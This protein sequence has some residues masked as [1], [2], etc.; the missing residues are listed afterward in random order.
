MS[1]PAGKMNK[2][3]MRIQFVVTG[4]DAPS[5]PIVGVVLIC[6]FSDTILLTISTTLEILILEIHPVPLDRCCKA[7]AACEGGPCPINGVWEHGCALFWE[8]WARSHPTAL[9]RRCAVCKLSFPIVVALAREANKKN[10]RNLPIS[11]NFKARACKAVR[12]TQ[13]HY[14]Q[15]F[16]I[17][18]YF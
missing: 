9:N 18:Y 6:D 11:Y 7:A 2:I 8:C 3:C 10:D 14:Q 1:L 16:Y 4:G 12:N 15:G 13:L 17:R 5:K